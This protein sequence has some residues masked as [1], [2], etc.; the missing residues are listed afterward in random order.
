MKFTITYKDI[1]GKTTVRTVSEI[2]II[3][4][5]FFDA[6]C[7][8][9]NEE[10]TFRFSRIVTA[11]DFETKELIDSLP[12]HLGVL[13]TKFSRKYWTKDSTRKRISMSIEQAHRLK[14]DDKYRLFKP[15]YFKILI[16]NAKQKL[17][18]LYNFK[19]F[20]CG[21]TSKNLQMD[22]HVPQC[23]GGRFVPNNI[24]ML[25]SRCNNIK[26]ETEPE[27]FYSKEQLY[28]LENYF[29]EQEKLFSFKLEWERW[30]N[31]RKQYLLDLNFSPELVQSIIYDENH[32]YYM[33]V[34]GKQEG[35]VISL[36]INKI[37]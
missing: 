1:N 17:R 10:R 2:E 27:L 16:D 9:V 6:F 25:C 15:F 11:C 4:E 37:L 36:D 19:C 13:D 21:R 12:I 24:V 18:A 31:D 3:D 32:P 22:H 29:S 7:H 30:H 23:L 20:N 33:G 35:V 14:N 8:L 34:G 5:D 28:E 26:N